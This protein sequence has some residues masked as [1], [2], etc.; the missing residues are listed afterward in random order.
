MSNC[1]VSIFSMHYSEESHLQQVVPLPVAPHSG[2]VRLHGL[3][4]GVELVG[5]LSCLWRPLLDLVV[6]SSDQKSWVLE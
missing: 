4:M 1:L 2:L 6:L 3:G 5:L